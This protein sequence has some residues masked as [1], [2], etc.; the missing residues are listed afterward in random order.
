MSVSMANIVSLVIFAIETAWR[1]FNRCAGSSTTVLA[2]N[3][4]QRSGQRGKRTEDMGYTPAVALHG[5][6]RSVSSGEWT[7]TGTDTTEYDFLWQ[8]MNNAEVIE[9]LTEAGARMVNVKP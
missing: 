2:V 9:A 7:G 5:I 8:M 6:T 3:A 1:P 4:G